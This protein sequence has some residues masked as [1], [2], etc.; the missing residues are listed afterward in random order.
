MR[1]LPGILALALILGTVLLASFGLLLATGPEVP[2]L[3]WRYIGGVVRFTL[4]Q[5]A[6]ST[7]ISLFLG[8]MLALALVRRKFP[9]KDLFIAA[10]NLASV[11]PAIVVVFAIVA[12][13]GRAGWIG[14]GARVFG[15]DFGGWLYGLSGIL[16]AHV[17]FNAPFAARIFLVSL[18]SVPGEHWRLAVQLGMGPGAIFRF[19]DWPVIKREAPAIA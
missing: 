11:L 4:F 3:P 13:L 15:I 12:V 6:L 7:A 2:S 17:F 14:Q 9:G 8:A 19:L 10:L 16:I 18:T 5:A 1:L